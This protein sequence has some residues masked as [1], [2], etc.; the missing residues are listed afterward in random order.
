MG[1]VR[2]NAK[3][4]W[5]LGFMG[6]VSGAG[7]WVGQR[8]A[9]TQLHDVT[10]HMMI[11]NYMRKKHHQLVL[12]YVRPPTRLSNN[13]A[14]QVYITHVFRMFTHGLITCSPASS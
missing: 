5:V 3:I 9:T 10:E 7:G 2:G 12:V 14:A 8:P 13:V 4:A 1:V 6:V 11:R